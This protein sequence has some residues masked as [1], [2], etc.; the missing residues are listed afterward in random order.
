[1][2]F[3]DEGSV[4]A[5]VVGGL[6]GHGANGRELL[7]SMAGFGWWEPRAS[8]ADAHMEDHPMPKSNPEMRIVDEAEPTERQQRSRAKKPVE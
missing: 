2:D 3:Y 8:G 5:D 7:A 4:H 1:M 6:E